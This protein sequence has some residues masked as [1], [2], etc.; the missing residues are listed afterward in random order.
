MKPEYF[1]TLSCRQSKGTRKEK[2]NN[3]DNTRLYFLVKI[4]LIEF[5]EAVQE[6]RMLCLILETEL[7][8][9]G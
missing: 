4:G 1:F 2:A 7:G 3:K 5:M 9:N 8:E 6:R